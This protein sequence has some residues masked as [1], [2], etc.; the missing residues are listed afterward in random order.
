[1]EGP[2]R[3]VNIAHPHKSVSNEKQNIRIM[4][5]NMDRDIEIKTR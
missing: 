5:L 2:W 3:K 4:R 1:M